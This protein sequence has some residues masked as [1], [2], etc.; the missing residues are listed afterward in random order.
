MVR[1]ERT[2]DA[3]PSTGVTPSSAKR[4]MILCAEHGRGWEVDSAKLGLPPA[5]W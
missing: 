3:Q 1:V 4:S 5:D 2:D